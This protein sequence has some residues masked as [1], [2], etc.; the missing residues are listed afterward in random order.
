MKYMWEK[1]AS[2]GTGFCIEYKYQ[3]LLQIST[4]INE[5]FYSDENSPNAY[6]E[7]SLNDLAFAKAV[8]EILFIKEMGVRK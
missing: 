6:F 3:D 2:N 1:Y 7:D 8:C 4:D 5:V